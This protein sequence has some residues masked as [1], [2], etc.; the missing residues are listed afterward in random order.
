M[1][2]NLQGQA[3][4]STLESEHPKVL[5]E[6]WSTRASTSNTPKKEHPK[7]NLVMHQMMPTHHKNG[8]M[9]DKSVGTDFRYAVEFSKIKR[10]PSKAFQ[11]SPGQPDQRYPVRSAVSNP[12]VPVLL[13]SR[14]EASSA[15][16]C[17]QVLVKGVAALAS[18]AQ[19][20]TRRT[21]RQASVR[22]KS[23]VET[24]PPSTRTAPVR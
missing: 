6:T 18:R 7:H 14:C 10:A 1:P 13:G 20:A 5:D 11:P 17:F 23:R 3:P 4:R 21:L 22:V 2:Y 15:E 9:N 12:L 8:C 19:L 16:T 24:L